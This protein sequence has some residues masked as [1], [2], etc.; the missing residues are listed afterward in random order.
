MRT[1][2]EVQINSVLGNLV[3]VLDLFFRTLPVNSVSDFLVAR[4]NQ[5]SP[6]SLSAANAFYVRNSDTQS[7]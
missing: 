6:S 5:F 2:E 1:F 4:F 3:C 7:L